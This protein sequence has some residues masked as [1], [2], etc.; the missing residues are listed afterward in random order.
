MQQFGR[1]DAVALCACVLLALLPAACAS[2][3]ANAQ[4][5][6]PP[7]S[8]PPV[9][10]TATPDPNFT[11]VPLSPPPSLPTANPAE[12]EKASSTRLYL[13]FFQSMSVSVIDP[14]SGHTLH[15]IPTLGDRAGA[16]VAPDGRRLYIVDSQLDGLLKVYD[17]ATWQVIYQAS[18]P[19]LATLFS[20][21]ISLSG[22]GRWLIIARYNRQRDRA[23]LSAFDTRR[24]EFLPEG[25]ADSLPCRVLPPRLAGRSGDKRIYAS[26][27][28]ALAAL[29]AETLARLWQVRTPASMNPDSALSTDR[30]RLFGLYPQVGTRVTEG[31]VQVASTDLLLYVWD[32]GSGQLSKQIKLSDQVLVPPATIGRGE[33]GY[34]R[35]APDGARLYM[36]WEDRL[37]ALATDS[38]RVA[39]EL[40]LP[41]PMDGVALS[42]DGRELY[43]L[44]AAAGDLRVR[45]QGLWTV[46]TATLK[47]I[48]HTLDW[49]GLRLIEPA[50]EA[51]PAPPS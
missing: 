36:V 26:C 41:A 32:A 39:G 38:L 48:R 5:G 35:L 42:V 10:V 14:L 25:A 27:S 28:D 18:V 30:T 4:P 13:S 37:W 51:A 19:D 34:L 50:F 40:Q 33:A 24:M 1:K 46:D 15:E 7:T 20:N 45:E 8:F 49:H 6:S 12:K 47:I 43:L 9:P 23:W 22:D 21:P 11:P 31:H 2:L 3:N 44:P 29:D 17:T 16:A